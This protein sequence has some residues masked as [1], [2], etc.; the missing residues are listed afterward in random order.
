[1]VTAKKTKKASKTVT[2]EDL[3]GDTGSIF[4]VPSKTKEKKKKK[5]DTG[6]DIF[7]SK[8]DGE[9]LSPRPIFYCIFL[10]YAK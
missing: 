8:D 7:S 1:M 9:F 6:K 4:D 3:F 10:F 5:S 2:D